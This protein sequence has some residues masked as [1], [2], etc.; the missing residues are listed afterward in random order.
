MPSPTSRSATATEPAAAATEPAALARAAATKTAAPETPEHRTHQKS[1][2]PAATAEEQQ[3]HDG[4]QQVRRQA[5]PVRPTRAARR[6]HGL[7]LPARG[8]RDGADGA[9]DAK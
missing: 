5:A 1:P 8:R 3:R 7:A 6:G 2:A 9:R 4:Q